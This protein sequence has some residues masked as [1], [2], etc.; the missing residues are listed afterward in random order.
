MYGVKVFGHA[1][2]TRCLFHFQPEV[3]FSGMKAYNPSLIFQRSIGL[4][5]YHLQIHIVYDFC[6][7]TGYRYKLIIVPRNNAFQHSHIS[8]TYTFDEIL[9]EIST[10]ISSFK[11]KIRNV[12]SPGKFISGKCPIYIISIHPSF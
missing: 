11:V 2:G 12:S 8:A 4:F 6:D 7:G 3:P 9:K 5:H 10:T 1:D